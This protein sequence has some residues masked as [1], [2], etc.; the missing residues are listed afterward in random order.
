MSGAT[1]DAPSL[2][3]HRIAVLG[4][5]A[6]GSGIG[7]DL[8]RAGLDVTFVDQWPA[9]VE[10]IRQ[11]GVRVESPTGAEVTEV[12]VLHLCE[13]AELR[14]RF[15]VVL[16][17]VKAYDTRWACELIKPYVAG[18]GVVVG[19]QNG[20]TT[21]DIVEIMGSHRA[22]GAVI[23]VTAAMEEPGIVMRHSGHDRSWFAVGAPDRASEHH[24]PTAAAILRH[25]GVV[26]I[27]DDIASAKWMK[28][29]LNA[30]E[31]VPSAILD[32][33]I[34]DC[35]RFE[36]MREIMLEA[37]NEAIRAAQL[38]GLRIRPIFGMTGQAA[39]APETFVETVLDELL[40]EYVLP[41]SRSTVL[42]DWSKGRRAEVREIN[43]AVVDALTRFGEPAPVNRA[44]VEL[45]LEIEAGRLT[46]GT[47][48]Q[49]VLAARIADLRRP[50]ASARP[51]VADDPYPL[52][53][54]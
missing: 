38:L 17:L 52:R 54:T 49:A 7:A 30:A 21:G 45:A 20:M 12:P 26:E 36:G 19:V 40:A 9:N 27:T 10:T 22:L 28:L 53:R 43:G 18:D 15:D 39:S 29:V 47:H 32:L 8:A 6:N 4:A 44:V 2:T 33:S 23:E 37:G 25:A 35:A 48:L 34:A 24:V 13:A 14:T 31:L 46:P 51:A 16:L 1:A 41:H 11:R 3:G 42:Q 5:G 50:T